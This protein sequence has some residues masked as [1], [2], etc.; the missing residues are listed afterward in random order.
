MKPLRHLAASSAKSPKWSV[1]IRRADTKSDLVALSQT[2]CLSGLAH[3]VIQLQALKSGAV[4]LEST[5]DQP[6]PP[7]VAA[8]HA[9][10]RR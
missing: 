4:D 10:V 6:A 1:L 9:E 8:P 7:Y 5:W 2:K 3:F